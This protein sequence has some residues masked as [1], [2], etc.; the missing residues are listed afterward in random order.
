M[1]NCLHYTKKEIFLTSQGAHIY[2]EHVLFVSNQI[3]YWLYKCTTSH[4]YTN[5]IKTI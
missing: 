4:Y 2:E 3:Y 1:D 5:I